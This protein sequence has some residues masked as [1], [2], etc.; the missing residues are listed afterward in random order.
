MLPGESSAADAVRN[1]R[2]SATRALDALRHPRP[3]ES[4]GLPGKLRGH[5]EPGFPGRPAEIDEGRW[6]LLVA[7]TRL[8]VWAD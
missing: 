8:A 5:S 3:K 2:A 6:A 1:E 7:E 4:G